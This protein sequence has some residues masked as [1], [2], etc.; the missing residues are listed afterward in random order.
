MTVRPPRQ[1]VIIENTESGCDVPVITTV[2]DLAD[3]PLG[4]VSSSCKFPFLF[5][6]TL[7]YTTFIFLNA[8]FEMIVRRSAQDI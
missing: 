3:H 4:M 2:P 5:Y 6:I 8:V 7:R 1:R